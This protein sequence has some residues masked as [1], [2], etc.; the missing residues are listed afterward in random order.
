MIEELARIVANEQVGESLFIIELESPEIARS[1]LPGQFVQLQI[2]Q[3]PDHILRRPFSILDSNA[4]AGTVA[5]LYR[6]VGWGTDA[7]TALPVG[8]DCS[9]IGPLGCGWELGKRRK[10]LLIGGG[11]GAAPLFMFAKEASAAGARVDAFVSATTEGGLVLKGRFEG[12]DGISMHYATD[13]GTLGFHGFCMDPVREM[14]ENAAECGDQFDAVYVCG[15]NP[16]MK[17]IAHIAVECGVTCFA[18]LENRMACGI[19]ACL[20][21]V[22]KTHGGQKR[23]CADGPVFDA[24]DIVW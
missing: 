5:I 12:I 13:D 17:A 10:V 16:L 14:L 21:C 8:I 22:V 4:E 20:S 23:V 19:G 6:V 3:T 1:V 11:V 18:S 9:L 24:A 15:P 2:P 7:M